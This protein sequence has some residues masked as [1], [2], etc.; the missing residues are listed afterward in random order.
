VAEDYA[1]RAE[2]ARLLRFRSTKSI[3][4]EPDV[5]LAGYVDRMQEGQDKIYYLLAPTPAA[6]A[7]SP[8]L[9]AYRKKGVEVLLFGEAVDNWVASSLQDF[10]GRRLV[11]A[12]QEVPDFGDPAGDG[13]QEAAEQAATDFAGLAG[14]IQ[15]ALGGKAHAV[16]VSSRLTTSPSCLVAG[17]PELGVSL[18]RRISGSGL[19][20][21]PVLEINPDHPLV[22]RLNT[23]PPDPHLAQWAQVLWNQAVLTYGAQIEDPAEFV[24]Q[25]NSL[26]T[27]LAGPG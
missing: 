1:N 16:R 11:S 14:R 26:L 27:G 15:D 23:E 7:S 25:L 13:E 22:A 24:G 19:P 6:A 2:I 9:E 5:S 20:A 10:D 8:L 4:G 17:E 21:Q 3:A 12:A 18:M